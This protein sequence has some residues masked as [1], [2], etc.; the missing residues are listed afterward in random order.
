MA[1]EVHRKQ[2]LFKKLQAPDDATMASKFDAIDLSN[3]FS[4]QQTVPESPF[5]H[6][7]YHDAESLWWI[8]VHSL[9]TTEPSTVERDQDT[10]RIQREHFDTLF[11]HHAAGSDARTDFLQN[12]NKYTKITHCLPNEFW[13]FT[14]AL[15][16]IRDALVAAYI[17][18]EA[19]TH[20]P[21]YD[22]FAKLFEKTSWFEKALDKAVAVAITDIRPFQMEDHHTR[23]DAEEQVEWVLDHFKEENHADYNPPE[24]DAGNSSEYIPSKGTATKKPINEVDK[25][26]S[27]NEEPASKRARRDACS[28]VVAN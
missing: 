21:R 26:E 5:L 22:H 16:I 10:Q 6:N 9:F 20:F 2:Y 19:Q 1:A 25:A 3:P 8:G 24:N 15:D 28:D 13:V 23:E 11:S 7:F 12:P 27:S 14:L 18:A 17:S 4:A